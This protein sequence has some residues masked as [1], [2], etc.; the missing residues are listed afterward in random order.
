MKKTIETIIKKRFG[1]EYVWRIYPN[2]RKVSCL[3]KRDAFTLNSEL[4][5][6]ITIRPGDFSTKSRL[7]LGDISDA[8]KFIGYGYTICADE[9]KFDKKT[10]MKIARLKAERRLHNNIMQELN[11]FISIWNNTGKELLRYKDNLKKKYKKNIER[12]EKDVRSI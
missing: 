6:I 1:I 10:G 8:Y 5:K 12:V 4:K 3:I 2:E 9:D 7:C 11:D